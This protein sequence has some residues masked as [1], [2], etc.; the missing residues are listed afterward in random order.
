MVV[1]GAWL[2][3]PGRHATRVRRFLRPWVTAHPGIAYGAVGV[4]YLAAVA[5]GPLTAFAKL[6]PVVLLAV[7]LALGLW[8]FHRQLVAESALTVGAPPADSGPSASGEQ[9]RS[10]DPNALEPG[11]P[12][13]DRPPPSDEPPAP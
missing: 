7:L 10:T 8:V 2:L 1:L 11:Q 9:Q 4:L 12:A 5:W 13:T 6:W 3:G